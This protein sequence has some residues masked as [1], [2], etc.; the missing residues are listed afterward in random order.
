MQLMRAK[1]SLKTC[2]K[3]SMDSIPEMSKE[4][5]IGEITRLAEKHLISI[6]I[7]SDINEMKITIKD[8]KLGTQIRY[9]MKH[10]NIPLEKEWML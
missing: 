3:K 4:Q 8:I 6:L 1:K 10:F 7:F 2:E 5:A 9:G